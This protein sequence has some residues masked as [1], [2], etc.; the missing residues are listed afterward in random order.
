LGS[1]L[2]GPFTHCQLPTG[3]W[4]LAAYGRDDLYGAKTLGGDT[5]RAI[6]ATVFGVNVNS[7]PPPA[8]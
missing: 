5:L 3:N 7:W 2:V 1:Q 6:T 4:T 8:S